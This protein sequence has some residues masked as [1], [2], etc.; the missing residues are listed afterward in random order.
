MSLHLHFDGGPGWYII[1]YL[2]LHISLYIYTLG[3][4]RHGIWFYRENAEKA[5]VYKVG[6]EP[7]PGSV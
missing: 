1:A 5:E 2:S 3:N 7:P 4:S 6:G